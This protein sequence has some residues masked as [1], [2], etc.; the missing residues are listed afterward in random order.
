MSEE[1]K[2]SIYC[3]AYNHE[4]YIR[5]T[6][7]GFLMQ[8]TDF[9]FEILIHDDASTDATADIIREYAAKHPCIKPIYQSV[10]QYSR[11]VRIGRTF[12]YPRIRGEYVAYCEGDDFW[13]DE[14][15][16]QKQIDYMDAHPE[17]MMCCHAYDKIRADDGTLI[18]TVRTLDSEG[19]ISPADAI[20]YNKRPTQLA[21]QVVRFEVLRDMPESFQ[22]AGVGDYPLLLQAVA[23]GTVHY[24]PD[25]MST[26]RAVS[27]GSWTERMYR[28]VKK[29]LEHWKRI[30]VFLQAFDDHY[31]G[32][33]H[34]EVAAKL[35]EIDY[36]CALLSGDYRRAVK[37]KE[38]RSKSLSRKAQIYVGCIFPGIARYVDRKRVEKRRQ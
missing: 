18:E 17:C 34:T 37:C 5:G 15:K 27:A 11:G 3:L 21:S 14:N 24:L 33:F 29:Q 12:Q 23:T 16:L 2:V 35:D 30:A 1:V 25:N 31:E 26:Y 28:D 38:F 13:T 22:S 4:K 36:R 20:S 7:D 8:K 32:R 19:D 10:N 9:P 6:L